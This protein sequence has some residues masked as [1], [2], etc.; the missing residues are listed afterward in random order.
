[1]G[2]LPRFVPRSKFL[3]ELV[4]VRAVSLVRSRKRLLFNVC[5]GRFGLWEGRQGEQFPLERNLYPVFLL[6]D[7]RVRGVAGEIGELLAHLI[8]HLPRRRV[9]TT[10]RKLG[11]L[12]FRDSVKQETRDA[13]SDLLPSVFKFSRHKERKNSR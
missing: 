7:F 10:D 11:I 4:A 1:M 5:V 6:Q 12:Q 13:R 2:G 3:V 8:N 9:L